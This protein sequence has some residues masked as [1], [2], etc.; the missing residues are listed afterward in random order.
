MK[1]ILISLLLLHISLY[2]QQQVKTPYESHMERIAISNLNLS[3]KQL[4][5]PN[6][7]ILSL[8]INKWT[9]VTITTKLNNNITSKLNSTN[10]YGNDIINIGAYDVRA[11]FYLNKRISLLNR[12]IITGVNSDKYFYSVGLII[13]FK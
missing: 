5:K 4:N 6:P 13:S 7:S 9:E 12:M 11:K 3:T 1:Y 10:V 2:A 8:V